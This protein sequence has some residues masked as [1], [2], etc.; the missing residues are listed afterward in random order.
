MLKSIEQL[1]LAEIVSGHKQPVSDKPLHEMRD[2]SEVL[3]AWRQAWITKTGRCPQSCCVSF[4]KIGEPMI[5]VTCG[6][7]LGK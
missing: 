7:E 6:H 4:S 1:A 5:C 2:E 3:A